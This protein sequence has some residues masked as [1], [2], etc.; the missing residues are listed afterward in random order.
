MGRGLIVST[1]GVRPTRVVTLTATPNESSDLEP[2]GDAGQ[3]SR[4]SVSRRR[5]LAGFLA[6]FTIVVVTST[7]NGS[8]F[9]TSWGWLAMA[10]LAFAATGLIFMLSVRISLLQG[11][12]FV[13]MVAFVGWVGLS[14]IWSDSV[15]GSIREVERDIVYVALA[16][17]LAVYGKYLASDGIV[18]GLLVG[19]TGVSGYAL[20]T[21]LFPS[22][23]AAL[24]PTFGDRLSVPLG[25]WNALGLFAAMGLILA[26]GVASHGRFRPLRMAAGA[27]ACLVAP[28]L[29]FTLSR[30]G[31]VAVA[32]GIVAMAILD[33]Q[34]VALIITTAVLALPIG[35]ALW[36]GLT[37]RTLTEPT[38]S[39]AGGGS[40]G[41]RY[42]LELIVLMCAAAVVAELA[43]G[44]TLHL[45]PGPRAEHWVAIGGL[46][47]AA[48]LVAGLAVAYGG[49]VKAVDRGVSAFRTVMTVPSGLPR[50][51]LFSVSSPERLEHWRV[52]FNQFRA[53]PVLG[54]GAGT[55]EQAWYRERRIDLNVRDAHNLYV[56]VLGE[57][58]VVGLVLL[59]GT[60]CVPLVGFALSRASPL[61]PVAAGAYVAYLAHAAIDWDWEVVGLTSI[62]IVA[63][64]AG[65][66][67]GRP[68]ALHVHLTR[69]VR[70]LLAAGALAATAFA[71][72]SV[73]G[74]REVARSQAAVKAGDQAR[75]I[76]SARLA[77]R[78]LRWSVEPWLALGEAQR[79]GGNVAGARASFERAVSVDPGNWRAWL[80]LSEVTTGSQRRAALANAR[81]LNPV[82][83]TN[84][85][86]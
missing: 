26:I 83:L 22:H 17:A 56:E 52:A 11:L 29:A 71:F 80:V 60:L 57:L 19:I 63:G 66:V 31:F 18:V 37:S 41:T 62:A 68:S 70:L 25:Y 38:A 42:A 54:S 47:V 59:L 86:R 30:G 27:A 15:S 64:T 32:V 75:A 48:A 85:S 7:H 45:A 61:V 6:A 76:T 12:F 9:P 2:E 44:V 40:A 46:G 81:R 5:D 36:L 24:D 14:A 1:P 53:Q 43:H 79:A 39:G 55:F 49:P 28:T 77:R 72:V 13:G 51:R 10:S 8:Y 84:S 34:R 21:R 69:P 65:L 50:D 16:L 67:G 23:F 3:R 4:L 58:G 78:T 82:G 73:V 20:A 74:N 33:R 35:A